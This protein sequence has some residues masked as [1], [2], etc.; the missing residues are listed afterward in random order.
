MSDQ[1]F[2]SIKI[3]GLDANEVDLHKWRSALTI[4]PQVRILDN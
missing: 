4:I 2:G 3:D 1:T